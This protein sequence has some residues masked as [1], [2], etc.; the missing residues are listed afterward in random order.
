[1]SVFI[2]MKIKCIMEALAVAKWSLFTEKVVIVGPS[3][4]LMAKKQLPEQWGPAQSPIL[5][6]GSPFPPLWTR[7]SRAGLKLSLKYDQYLNIQDNFIEN[8][9][10]SA[11][12]FP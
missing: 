10:Y 11:N 8:G 1:M 5:P 12:F 4:P 6:R 7:W 9:P 3:L 2:R